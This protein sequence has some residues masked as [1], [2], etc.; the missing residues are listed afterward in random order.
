MKTFSSIEKL[1]V[2]ALKLSLYQYLLH[3]SFVKISR[4]TLRRYVDLYHCDILAS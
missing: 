3:F 2:H 1:Q 4:W